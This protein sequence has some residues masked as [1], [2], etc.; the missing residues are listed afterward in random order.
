M[1]YHVKIYDGEGN[2]LKTVQPV[3]DP[4][5]KQTRK[6][7]SHPCPSCGEQTSK[8]HYCQNCIIKRENERSQK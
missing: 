4:N 8:K 6:F 1:L 5:P 7:L 2:Y 3:F